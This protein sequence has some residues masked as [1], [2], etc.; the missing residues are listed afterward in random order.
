MSHLF[1]T[2]SDTDV[3]KTFVTAGLTHVLHKNGKKVCP[4]KPVQSGGE[5]GETGLEPGD[6][7]FVKNMTDLLLPYDLMNTY[8]L[9]EPISPHRAAEKEGVHLVPENILDHYYFL[10]NKFDH[11]LVEGAGGV[12]VP[13]LRN[14]FYMYDL[15]K[16]LG[17]PAI[18]VTRTAVGTINHT[19]L[20]VHY[21]KSIG[22]HIKA[23]IFNGYEGHDY[24]DDN[25]KILKDI[26][27][28]EQ[29]FVLPK[30]KEFS[31]EKVQEVYEKHLPFDQVL[32]LLK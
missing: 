10:E 8:C 4:Y 24:E 5:I 15:M 12:V 22:I 2:G 9:K 26:T 31:R 21:L 16:Q 6:C 20:T 25:I 14:S 1:I 23:I 27:Q 28:I 29:I 19:A 3:G 30:V 32:N 11:V 18:V 13:L 17:I 7:K